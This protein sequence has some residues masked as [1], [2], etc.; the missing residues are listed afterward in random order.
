VAASIAATARTPSQVIG[1]WLT[2]LRVRGAISR[3]SQGS[4]TWRRPSILGSILVLF[5]ID[6]TLLLGAPLAH[7][8]AL[9]RAAAELF[10]V[11]VSVDDIRAIRPGGRTD[12]EI[13]RL[14]LR[15]HGVGDDRITDG[16]ARWRARAVALYPEIRGH[17]A[18]QLPAP[19]ASEALIRTA[20]TGAQLALL[21]GNLEPI[22]HAKVGAAG[23]DGWF[24]PGTGAFGSDHEVRDALVP[25]AVARSGGADPVVVVGDTPRDIACARA[26]GARCIGVTT[27]IHDRGALGAADAVVRNLI[28]AAEILET[29][30]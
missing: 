24:A 21:T 18:P 20:A 1:R 12:Q 23:L 22:A 13:A 30:Q 6:G 11:E 29:W 27:G 2:D 26:G 5:D 3:G 9:S 14:I 28:K 17:H 10:D 7:T 4:L 8:E 25:I 19:G 15:R 16:L